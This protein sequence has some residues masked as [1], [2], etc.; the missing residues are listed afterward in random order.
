MATK[1]VSRQIADASI[2]SM[3]LFPK[4]RFRAF[5]TD[6]R[7]VPPAAAEEV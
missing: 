2:L 6:A 3:M 1:Q 7:V 4:R 5:S